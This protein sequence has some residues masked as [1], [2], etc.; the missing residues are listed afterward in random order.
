M[1]RSFRNN[2]IKTGDRVLIH[3]TPVGFNSILHPE[4]EYVGKEGNVVV[5][6]KDSYEYSKSLDEFDYTV[7]VVVDGAINFIDSQYLEVIESKGV[8][9]ASFIVQYLFVT[10]FGM[11]LSILIMPESSAYGM[12]FV[13]THAVI[14]FVITTISRYVWR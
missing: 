7:T 12:E 2:N 10:L 1:T 6:N 8:W 14:A 3:S 5:V 9:T 13:Y 11:W 4:R